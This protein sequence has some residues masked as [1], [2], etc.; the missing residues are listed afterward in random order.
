M[1]ADPWSSLA[2]SPENTPGTLTRTGEVAS[3]FEVTTTEGK[4]LRLGD[5]RGQVVVVSFF[6]TWCGPC[7]LELPHLDRVWKEHLG[8]RFAMV[9]IGRAED[10]ELMR[11]S[12]EQHG[13][14]FSRAADPKG[15]VYQRYATEEIPQPRT[16]HL[17]VT[18]SRF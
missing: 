7:L 13:F 11:S 4:Q 6:A 2:A 1:V 18:G 9:V 17:T 14:S 15:L 5:L 3:D 12:R 8:H 16:S 10:D